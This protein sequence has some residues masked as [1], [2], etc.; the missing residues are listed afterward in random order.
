MVG[1]PNNFT[2]KMKHKYPVGTWVRFYQNGVLVIGVVEYLPDEEPWD[3]C[4]NYATTAGVVDED[5]IL[6][7]RPPLKK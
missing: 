7:A 3:R 5:S 6:E 1:N 2:S 4:C